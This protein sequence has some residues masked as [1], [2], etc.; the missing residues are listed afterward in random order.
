MN[1]EAAAER[2]KYQVYTD[3]FDVEADIAELFVDFDE[4]VVRALSMMDD[5]PTDD[6]HERAG[7]MRE[8]LVEIVRE[9]SVDPD[10]I[11]VV[12]LM[13]NS[14]KARGKKALSLTAATITAAKALETIGIETTV[15]GNTTSTWGNKSKVVQ[16]FKQNGRP[17]HPGRLN[18]ILHIV[19]KTPGM[20]MDEA[21]PR[22]AT[23]VLS[24]GRRENVDGEAL[25]WAALVAFE[26]E[27]SHRLVVHVRD[28]V[29]VDDPTMAY[30]G[31]GYLDRHYDEVAAEI[32]GTEIVLAGVV[33]FG[34]PRFALDVS[35]DLNIMKSP[36]P[37]EVVDWISRALEAGIR[38]S[39]E[40]KMTAGF[41][42]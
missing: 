10:D 19:Y 7:C 12:F 36:E 17:F 23:A 14:G 39:A 4:A 29:P 5:M 24:E 15:L 13:D 40:L 31:D 1:F 33:L 35:A 16:Q 11:S 20:T 41:A 26:R 6:L 34:K 2:A 22:I 42:P 32:A 25:E 37:A 9:L 8:E 38:A 18:D 21:T 27:K 28:S 3:E 30:N